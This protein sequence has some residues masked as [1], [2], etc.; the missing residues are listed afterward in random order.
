MADGSTKRIQKLESS[1]GELKGR[2]ARLEIAE[3]ARRKAEE[4]AA[5]QPRPSEKDNASKPE[6]KTTTPEPVK[7]KPWRHKTF[8]WWKARVEFVGIFFAIGYAI[9]T[10]MQWYDLRHNFEVDQRAW[11]KATPNWQ[12][13]IVTDRKTG[14]Y[15]ELSNLGKSAIS[16]LTGFGGLDLVESNTPLQLDVNEHRSVWFIKG[17]IF[18]G[19]KIPFEIDL[20]DQQRNRERPFTPQEAEELRT[21][22]KY[23]VASGIIG[24]TDQF[25]YHWFQF[26]VTKSYFNEM[27]V[28]GM[29][30][31]L[32]NI[33][34][35]GM[36]SQNKLTAK[37]DEAAKK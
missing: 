13:E 12:T 10:Y 15:F 28:D 8:E 27:M 23:L 24:Y 9:V 34:G 7:Q 35:D 22:K 14:M 18:P 33:I 16:V 6:P 25:G 21:G 1:L 26:C 17:P 36:D 32:W 19:D 37:E 4:E 20:L 11:V 2:L 30:C 5:Q 3:E 31:A 29:H